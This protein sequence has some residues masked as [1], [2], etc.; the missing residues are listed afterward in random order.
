MLFKRN[1]L[2]A[3]YGYWLIQVVLFLIISL[4]I[5]AQKTSNDSRNRAAGDTTLP[6]GL[7]YPIHDTR[8]E[9]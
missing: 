6:T 1:L 5:S 7:P 2:P 9:F 4:S 8:G 3:K